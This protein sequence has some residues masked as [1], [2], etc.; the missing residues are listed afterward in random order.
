MTNPCQAHG[1]AVCCYDTE[2]PL[3]EDDIKRLEALGHDRSAFITWSAHGT[4]QLNTVEPL[5]GQTER[6][7][8]F[9]KDNVCSVYA[10]RPAGCRIY[11]LVLN[12]HGK[13]IRDADCPHRIEFPMDPTAKRRIQRIVSNL[14]REPT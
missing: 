6:P 1:C 8:F 12:E 13:L 10:D 2:M 4:A 14:A 9:L 3:T 7:C 11:P 5:E